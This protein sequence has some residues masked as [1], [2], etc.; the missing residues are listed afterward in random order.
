MATKKVAPMTLHDLLLNKLSVLSD[1]ENQLIKA[2]PKMA[3]AATDLELSAGFEGH[4][5][6]TREHAR[7]LE[8]AFAI[9]KQKPKKLRSE[10]I[11]G[12]VE[13]GAWVIKNVT[14]DEA[15]DANLIAAAQYVEHYAIAGYGSALEWATEMGHEEVADLLQATLDE[16]KDTDKKLNDLARGKINA[17]VNTGMNEEEE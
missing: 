5:K 3:K 13:D 16:E 2:L 7:R 17:K 4:L 11:R 6:Q 1:V 9:L 12:L 14:G 10:A 8:Q 15:L